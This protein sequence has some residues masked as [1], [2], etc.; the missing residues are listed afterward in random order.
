[1]S[2][3]AP[4]RNRLRGTLL[5][6]RLRAGELRW[7]LGEPAAGLETLETVRAELEELVARE[8][9]EVD[10]RSLLGQCHRLIGEL[11]RSA[12][13][14]GEALAAFR[15]AREVLEGVWRGVPGDS[16][17]RQRLARVH[18]LTGR[19]L[20]ARGEEGRGREEWRRAVELLEGAEHPFET[21]LWLD[22]YAGALLHLGRRERAAPVVAELLARGWNDPELL[23]LA[24]GHGLVEKE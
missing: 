13:R 11:H 2:T 4:E 21:D 16:H 6:C 5:L 14:S 15:A 19:V 24:R 12:G 7:R 1:M 8:P 10:L 9:E 23:A 22:S 20:A 3:G 18:L 17:H